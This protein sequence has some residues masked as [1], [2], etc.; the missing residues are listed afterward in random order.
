MNHYVWFDMYDLPILLHLW[1]ELW[2]FLQLDFVLFKGIYFL[3]GFDY[4]LIGLAKL[5]FYEKALLWGI[6]YHEE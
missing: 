1:W 2:Y 4:F 5:L 3:V 6:F